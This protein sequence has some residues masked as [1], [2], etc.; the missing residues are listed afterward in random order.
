M[1]KN[2]VST[3]GI[4]PES[5][6]TITSFFEIRVN[7]LSLT[8][9]LRSPNTCTYVRDL[10]H[11]SIAPVFIL[12]Y[13]SSEELLPVEHKLQIKCS[14]PKNTNCTTKTDLRFAKRHKLHH[15]NGVSTCIN[16]S[17]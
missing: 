2:L 14:M 4:E 8:H 7:R 9:L 6:H 16:Q 10:P 13:N 15:Q 3:L 17:P 5:H 12:P 11:C 1:T